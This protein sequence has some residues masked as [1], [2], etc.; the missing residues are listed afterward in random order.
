[1]EEDKRSNSWN[2]K[3]TEREKEGET[4]QRNNGMMECNWQRERERSGRKYVTL[5]CDNTEM[6]H[7]CINTGQL[8]GG[9][10]ERD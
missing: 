10:N 4:G 9:D 6:S 2:D 5:S 1:M 8:G 7:E 3:E